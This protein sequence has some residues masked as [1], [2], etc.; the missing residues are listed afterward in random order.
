LGPP[1]SKAVMTVT[2]T[3]LER[4]G[5]TVLQATTGKE[6]IELVKSYNGTINIALLDFVLPDMN[7]DIIYPLIQKHHPDMKV[8]VLSGY[9]I[10][11]PVQKLMDSGAQAFIQKPVS[12][13]EL[14]QKI[15]KIL[16][17]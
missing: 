4:K 11:G 2:K 9:A 17:Q 7:G 6:A 1:L 14:I 10:T 5:Y 16:E 13:K 8:I 12:L 3:M 15:E